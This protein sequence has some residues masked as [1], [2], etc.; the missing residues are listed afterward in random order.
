MIFLSFNF[1]LEMQPPKRTRSVA[2]EALLGGVSA[3]GACVIS[4]PIDV[5]RVRMQ[6][7]GQPGAS[8]GVFS[9]LREVAA[10]R[11]GLTAGLAPALSHT[12][13]LNALRFSTFECGTNAGLPAACSGLLA[14][15]IAGFAASPLARARTLLQSDKTGSRISFQMLFTHPFTGARAWGLRNAGHTAC[16]FSLYEWSKGFVGSS[17]PPFAAHLTASLAAS[18]ASCL[19][20]NPVDL[21]CTRLFC[22]SAIVSAAGTASPCTARLEA[23]KRISALDC[24]RST[25]AVEGIGGFYNGLSANLMRTVPHTVLTFVFLECLRQQLEVYGKLQAA[26]PVRQGRT[27]QRTWTLRERYDDFF[28]VADL[29][30]HHVL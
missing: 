8:R 12:V 20:M 11:A 6:M 29:Q 10:S 14:G 21:V 23:P 28:I 9:S 19:L 3:A 25:V 15:F 27:L 24:I 1:S 26:A 2:T 4:N 18:C 16:I 7:Q 5:V 30:H 22:S 13:M 17:L